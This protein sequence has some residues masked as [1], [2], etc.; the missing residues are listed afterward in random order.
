[1]TLKVLGEDYSEE[2]LRKFF[3]DKRKNQSVINFKA[4]SLSVDNS[5]IL[6]LQNELAL[7]S[8]Q[9]ILY[10][11]KGLDTNG[12]YPNYYNSRYM[13]FKRYHQLVDTINFLNDHK[14]YNYNDL[15]IEL[16][17]I[18]SE[19]AEKETIYNEQLSKNETLQLRIPLC[20]LY[21]SYLDYYESYMEQKEMLPYDVEPSN[22][23]KAFLELKKELQVESTEEVKQILTSANGV[24]AETNKQ[25]S[26]L[27][28]LKNK[29]S[30]LERIKSISLETEK[31]FIKSVTFSKKMI[32]ESR[33]SEKDY[34][35][36][37]P[38]SNY[39]MYVPKN[40]VAWISYDNRGILYLIDDKEYV[41]Y[42]QY[43]QEVM[44]AKGE[45]IEN[46]SQEEKQ[47][48][49]EYYKSKE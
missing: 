19:I 25:L 38:Y 11:M 16:E 41:L 13:E 33:S 39:Y 32:D 22:E 28:Y 6:N 30:E 8:K 44:R 34:C 43:N 20:N 3:A 2:A 40:Q 9:S 1:M 45:E 24:K 26:Y 23:V 12:D 15:E 18:K 35:L 48:V 17:K 49:S 46:I 47:K 42:D 7:R 36:R 5:E 4:Y 14:I 27:S 31:G 21:M 37:I 10:S 29:A